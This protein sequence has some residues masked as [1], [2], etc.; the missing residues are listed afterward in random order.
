MTVDWKGNAQAVLQEWSECAK[1]CRRLFERYPGISQNAPRPRKDTRTRFHDPNDHAKLNE[2]LITAFGLEQPSGAQWPG[3]WSS[4]W[5]PTDRDYYTGIMS[6]EGS[7]Y[8]ANVSRSD[9]DSIS[10][11]IQRIVQEHSSWHKRFSPDTVS[12]VMTTVRVHNDAMNCERSKKED[13][14]RTC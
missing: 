12:S 10:C 4:S 1:Y 11:N 9:G 14:C 5:V 8:L 3:K 7:D 2:A 13:K 6:G